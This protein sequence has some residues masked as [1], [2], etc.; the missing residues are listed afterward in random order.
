M[1]RVFVISGPTAV[2][3]GTVV[4]RLQEL[5][6]ELYV[7][8]SVTTRPPRPGEQDGVAYHFINDAEF[9]RL[10]AA[11]GLLEWARVHGDARY[12]T[13]RQPVQDAV[14]AGRT[15]ILEIDLQGARRVRQT[16]PEA[17]QIFLAP[18]TWDELVRRLTVR[19]TETSNQQRQRLADAR[20]E[21][22]HAAEFD[23]VVVNGELESTV[24]ELVGLLGL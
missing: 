18:P 10:I 23:H 1:S 17:I 9:D 12:G 2:G 15:V 16:Y 21:L 20:D 8:T 13:L 11:D 5:H 22:A 6:P 19:G 14:A 7:S 4:K 24:N 3:K